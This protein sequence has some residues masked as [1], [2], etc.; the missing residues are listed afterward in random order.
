M[1][2]QRSADT[3][4]EVELR[5]ELF[6]HGLR[7]RVH[8]PVPGRARRSIDVAFTRVRLAV[9]VDG[10]FWHNCPAHGRQPGANPQYWDAKLQRNSVRDDETTRM[11][12]DAGWTVLRFWEHVPARQAADEVL[13]AYAR[14]RPERFTPPLK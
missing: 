5:R 10:C 11:L 12:E 13:Q 14:L 7:Y 6:A 2:K 4:P 3:D 1:Q 8:F 9:F